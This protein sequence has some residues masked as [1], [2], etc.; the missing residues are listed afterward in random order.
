MT[1]IRRA[2]PEDY[3]AFCALFPE[4]QVDDPIPNRDTWNAALAPSTWVATQNGQVV[5]YCYIQ[6]YLDTGYVRNI[7]T[8]PSA[9][10]S[11]VA[12][13]LMHEVAGHLHSRGKRWR[14]LNVKRD[15]LPARALYDKLGMQTK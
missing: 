15:N 12:T 11:G 4:L 13:S 8:A 5:G 7:V 9:R 2:S 1:V 14:R 3:D 10:R 6:E